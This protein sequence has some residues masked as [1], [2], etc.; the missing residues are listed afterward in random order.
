MT[1]QQFRTWIERLAEGFKVEYHYFTAPSGPSSINNEGDAA[2]SLEHC[3]AALKDGSYLKEYDA[4]LVA[5]YSHHPLV[6]W[7]KDQPQVK[8]KPV[9]GIFEAS[10]NRSLHSI[11]SHESFGIVS[12]GKV[13]EKLLSEAVELYFSAELGVKPGNKFAG[14]E[15]T[16][17][18]ATELHDA[19]AEEVTRRMKDATKRLVQKGSVGAVC[20]GCAG[21]TG[22]DVV[23]GDAINEE[24]GKAKGAKVTII[25]GVSAGLVWLEKALESS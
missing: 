15:T 12:T 16:G 17:L 23:V 19:P 20:L 21:M 11:E 3:A 2:E 8:G 18:N 24:L 13:W 22:M 7:L 5:C 1:S 6:Q 25:D 14:V 9:T 4:F 10:V